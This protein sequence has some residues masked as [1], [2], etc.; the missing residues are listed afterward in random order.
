MEDESVQVERGAEV[1]SALPQI[2]VGH[3][4]SVGLDGSGRLPWMM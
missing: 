3:A 2:D 1:E 4:A